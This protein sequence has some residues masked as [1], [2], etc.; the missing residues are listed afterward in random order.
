VH[1]FDLLLLLPHLD[2]G[3]EVQRQSK[4][5]SKASN[6]FDKALAA[7]IKTLN[8]CHFD[9]E[10]NEQALYCEPLMNQMPNFK[11]KL[12]FGFHYGSAIEGTR[13]VADP[14]DVSNIYIP[15]T[16]TLAG[17]IG[18]SFRFES[19]F[20]SLNADFQTSL[21]VRDLFYCLSVNRGLNT[22]LIILLQLS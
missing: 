12:C 8:S 1:F 9:Q 22:K 14:F 20:A 13:D 7:M 17:I 15:A 10:L 2:S 6:T 19:C 16:N 4:K 18:S 21:Q 5:E 11:L 3:M